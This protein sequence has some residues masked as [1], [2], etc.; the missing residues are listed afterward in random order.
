MSTRWITHKF[1]G[2]SL[3]DA[4]AFGAVR[5]ILVTP[6]DFRQA[7]VVSAVAG[8]TD[9]LIDLVGMAG[10]RDTGYED[11]ARRIREK[12]A[13]LIEQLA[14]GDVGQALLAQVDNEIDEILGLLKASWVMRTSTSTTDAVAG[15]GELWSA[16][17]LAA[18]LADSGLDVTWMDARE[19]LVVN[20]AELASAVDWETSLA[21]LDQWLSGC[22]AD[23][24]VITGFVASDSQGSPTTLGRNGSDYSASIFADLLSSVEISIW[25][26]VDGVLS[27]DPRLVPEAKVLE[28]LSYDEA[29]ELAYF[30]AEVLHP[31]AMTPAVRGEIPIY[32]RNTFNPSAP[33]TRIHVQSSTDSP[34]KGFASIGSVALLN[35]EGSAMVG[36]PG[37]SERLFG[38]LRH[39]GVSV[40]MISQGSSEH[41]I[42]FA[43]PDNQS[44]LASSTIES[45]FETEQKRG[46]QTLEVTDHCTILA[47]VGDTM[48]GTPGVAANFFGALARVGVNVRAIA[49]GS[50]ER[51]ISV[52]IDEADAAKALRAAHAG[53]YLSKQTLSI[54]LVGPGHVGSTFLD[55]LAARRDWLREEFGVDLRV[56]AIC[57]S[58]EMIVDEA[59]IELLRWRARLAEEGV[60]TDLDGLAKY[61]HTESVPHAVIIDCTASEDVGSRYLDW[62][63]QGIH[64]ITPNKKANTGTLD[65]YRSLLARGRRADAHYLYETT[66]GAA[67]PILQ[68]LRDL[69]QTGD[70]ILRIEGILS[71]TLSYL[72]NS[73]DG[74]KP[75]SR[76]VREAWEKGYTEPDP[77][78]DLSGMDVGRKVVILAREIG[79]DL[80]LSDL[81]IDGLV[82]EGLENG[83]VSEFLDRLGDHDDEME[84]LVEN[85]RSRGEVLRFVGSIATEENCSVALR[86]YP[87]DHPF[88]RI[89]LTDNI[90]Q[91]KTRRYK[92]NPLVVQGPGAGPE[93]TAG[94]V[95]ADLLR[96]ASYLGAT[97]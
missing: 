15:Y 42:C 50:S 14:P 6:T 2:T 90:V 54:G 59:P 24:L 29:M 79:M 66:V 77:R 88:A 58:K 93:V 31:A 83:S 51:N 20:P 34:V 64:V 91:F 70:E 9:D 47:V 65:Y 60:P 1:G 96:L 52:V 73:F 95:F 78:E 3:A 39:A 11:K 32:I 44:H 13:A 46:I 67:L 92:D 53:F 82:P 75:F 57:T 38:A 48:S 81:K 35:L 45:V 22:D 16:R 33:G 56:R 21:N 26:D 94:G 37:I 28:E 63:S 68:T 18:F 62:L 5:D 86:S 71:G 7:V 49:Q 17:L 40:V 27:A 85:A 30:G 87:A 69:V 55:Q 23:T 76:I 61:V 41:S 8:V 12:Q 80:S 89:Q 4:D 97:L 19:V 36:V 72:F 10:S 74:T 25:T 43:I 84:E